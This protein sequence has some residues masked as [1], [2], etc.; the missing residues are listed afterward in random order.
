MT[1]TARTSGNTTDSHAGGLG[2]SM[3]PRQLVM[4]GLGSAIG[5]GLFLGSGAG[6]QAAGPAVL[7]SYLIAGTLVI[8]V[9]GALGEMAAAHPSSGAFSTYADKAMGPTA[10]ATIGWL[11]WGQLVIVIAAEAVGAAGLI[12]SVWPVLPVWLLALAFMVVFTAVNLLGVR[13]YGEFEF[14]FA[15]IKI[16]AILAFLA[17]GAALMA[18][19]LPQT[20]SPGLTNFLGPDG[21]APAGLGG[22]AAGLLVVIFA[23][24]GTEIVAVAAAETQD[25]Q[26]SVARAVKTVVWRILVFYIGSVLVITL[27]VPWDSPALDSP[28]A[29]VLA[30]ARIPGADVAITL[31]AAVALLSALNANLYGASRM[32]FSLSRRGD[33]PARLQRTAGRNVPVA[34]V[35]SS[36]AFGFAATVLELLFPEKVLPLLL[37]FVGSTCLA[38]WAIVLVSQ[39]ILRRRA[40]R[41]GQPLPM[42]LP[43]YP[44][45]SGVGLALLAA[46]IIIGLFSPTTAVQLGS[47]AALI[48]AIAI[49]S[50]V[51][52]RRAANVEPTH[53]I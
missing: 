33:A 27:V 34:A 53:S 8:I 39:L 9:M 13:N 37:N 46:I 35:L 4:M 48:A 50:K 45:T 51:A 20:S 2:Q 26:R 36:V 17:I 25:P 7:V 5:A 52:K 1:R 41:E 47:T 32:I 10:G 15:I 49:F 6:V 24:G 28:F 40:V 16:V 21:F 14:W 22:I 18:G 44:W 12:A 11:W 29:A 38:V 19:W 42:K 30:Q 31:V 43:G 23:F 3:K